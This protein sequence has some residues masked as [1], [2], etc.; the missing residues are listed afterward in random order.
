[1]FP[2]I[3]DILH[4]QDWTLAVVRNRYVFGFNCVLT[5][6]LHKSRYIGTL[7]DP[8][9]DPLRCSHRYSRP[10]RTRCGD[11]PDCTSIASKWL[12]LSKAPVES[13]GSFGSCQCD[14]T[15]VCVSA[16][17]NFPSPGQELQL[18]QKQFPESDP[19]RCSIGRGGFSATGHNLL[20]GPGVP[21]Y[22]ITPRQI[23]TMD[24]ST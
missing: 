9:D 20:V 14:H 4:V 17:T 13:G 5:G 12:H 1:M 16:P 19:S 18:G 6:L 21:V 15:F 8:V 11:F 23:M 3:D 10:Q 24:T 2:H 22:L 7:A